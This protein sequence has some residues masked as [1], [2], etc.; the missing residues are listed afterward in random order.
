MVDALKKIKTV[1]HPNGLLISIQP[2]DANLPLSV[3]VDD[4]ATTYVGEVDVSYNFPRYQQA[5]NAIEMATESGI[6]EMRQDKIVDYYVFF[7]TITAC[8]QYLAEEWTNAIL[9]EAAWER[10]TALMQGKG[11]QKQIFYSE[12]VRFCCLA[13]T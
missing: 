1:L 9:P 3:Q 13:P 4:R 12:K 10:M 7:D 11:E 2:Q 8:R 6:F 5:N